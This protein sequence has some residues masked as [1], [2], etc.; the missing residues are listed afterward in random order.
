MASAKR[1]T[2]KREGLAALLV[3]TTTLVGLA[4][5]GCLSSSIRWDR[6]QVPQVPE[7]SAMLRVAVVPDPRAGF[8]VSHYAME[9]LATDLR[10]T[11]VFAEVRVGDEGPADLLALARWVDHGSGCAN[12]LLATWVTFGLVPVTLPLVRGY[13]FDFASASGEVAV[14]FDLHYSTEETVTELS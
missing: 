4:T 12:P 6:S 2:R 13:Y 3:V 8:E 7:H 5:G 10:A 14:S 1:R 9:S 11:G